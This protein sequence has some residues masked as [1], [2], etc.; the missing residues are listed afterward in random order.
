MTRISERTRE[1]ILKAAIPLFAERGY[2]GAGI[3]TLV[4]KA[5][6]NQAAINYHFDGKDGLYRAILTIA[7]EALTKTENL[8]PARLRTLDRDEALRGFVEQQLRPLLF[9][10]ELSRYVRIFSWETLRPTPVFRRFMAEEG[11]PFLTVATDLVRRFLPD[12]ASAEEAMTA[13]IW[14]L[15]QCTIFVRNREQLFRHEGAP[16]IDERFVADLTDRVSRW[17]VGGLAAGAGAA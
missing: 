9:R 7:F 8:D 6:V 13:A 14:L 10:D 4:A 11:V 15:G 5:K 2:D 12:G 1:K 16:R 3:R 17:A